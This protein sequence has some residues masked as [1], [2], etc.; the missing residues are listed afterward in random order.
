MKTA[1]GRTP[2]TGV[3]R[4]KR[5]RA[6]KTSDSSH[7]TASGVL[8][9][10]VGLVERLIAFAVPQGRRFS[11]EDAAVLLVYAASRRVSLTRACADLKDAMSDSRLRQL[12]AKFDL[13][14]IQQNLN[15]LLV[16]RAKECLGKRRIRLAVDY[17]LVP[18][19]GKPHKR[20]REVYRGAARS[21]TSHFHAYATAY[22]ILDG[23]RFT[24]AVK[25]VR[26]G[27][28]GARVVR[29][30][31]RRVQEAG[32]KIESLYADRGFCN[33]RCI[34][35]FETL[36]FEILMPLIIRGKKGASVL[37]PRES[38]ATTYTMSSPKD[39]AV[40]FRV[41]V[42]VVY[43][44]G[45]RGK[46]RTEKYAYVAL[47]CTARPRTVFDR[48]R[49]RFGIEA[50]YRLAGHARART[51]TRNP[52]I[53]LVL[54]GI[55]L[56]IENEWVWIK[57]DRLSVPHR[58]RSGRIV[59]DDLLPFDLFL[60]WIMHAVNLALHLVAEVSV[61]APPSRRKRALSPLQ[62]RGGNY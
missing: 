41:L 56:L 57:Y 30:L 45:R 51:C 16:V 25:F 40:T 15:R 3:T 33:V 17:H 53:R 23:R 14:R 1:T 22:V 19:H 29:Y 8:A 2:R 37:K 54:F 46:H 60:A 48:Y 39:G 11:K 28:D 12:W 34:R 31:L 44:K 35:Y 62:E 36:P 43:A 47:H 7:V 20:K 21:G 5:A 24:L 58:G 32:F 26:K 18:Y 13:S 61:H 38:H 52:G 9:A 59:Q 10:V 50:S 4:R 27:E 49:G 55:A 6:S 42:A